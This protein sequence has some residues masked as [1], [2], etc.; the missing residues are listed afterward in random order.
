[1]FTKA[2]PFILLMAIVAGCDKTTVKGPGDLK[3]TLSKPK[4]ATI[5]RNNTTKVSVN[6][7]R[8]NVTGPVKVEFNHLPSGVSVVDTDKEV[9]G[10]ERTFVLSASDKAAIVQNHVANVS[11]KGPDGM[12][13]TE[14]FRIN[15]HEKK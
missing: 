6:F 11:I 2:V 5:E 14:E 7:T 9:E 12:T 10:N 4:D 3:L 1:M 8:N 13:A 15:V